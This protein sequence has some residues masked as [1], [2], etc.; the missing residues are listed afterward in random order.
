[1]R[2]ERARGN[3]KALLDG[4]LGSATTW[5]L[6]RH[7]ARCAGCQEEFEMIGRL[8]ALLL[9]AD[10][11][12]SVPAGSLGVWRDRRN[13]LRPLYPLVWAGMLALA[14][15]VGFHSRDPGSSNIA[16]AAAIEAFA[17]GKDWATWHFVTKEPD[18]RLTET[19]LRR[20][21]AFR[22]EIRQG[23]QLVE[24]RVQLGRESWIYQPDQ[25]RA[26]HAHKPIQNP[27]SYGDA[28]Y[29]LKDLQRRASKVGGLKV[30]ERPD[31][32]P[33]GRAVK[34]IDI[35]ADYAKH[36][37]PREGTHPKLAH[38]K[39]VVDA[40]TG[41]QVKSE[42]WNSVTTTIAHNQPMPDRLFVWK[43]PA[44][45]QVI[46][47]GDWQ[48][49]RLARTLASVKNE[50][51]SLTIHAV[52]LAANGDL[53]VTASW[54]FRDESMNTW[55][56]LPLLGDATDDRG[57]VYLIFSGIGGGGMG[58]TSQIVAYTPRESRSPADPLPTTIA[59]HH[60]GSPALVL[61]V[62]PPAAWTRPPIDPEGV[63]HPERDAPTWEKL[64]Q[65]VRSKAKTGEGRR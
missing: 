9:S 41:L 44:G 37:G 31:R 35:E 34:V 7:L 38:F 10:L 59:L 52:D 11:V 16:L 20:P 27:G 62:P 54:K 64:R 26:F 33:D 1:M 2:C 45:V 13:R 65:K 50:H 8:N 42:M 6:R 57:R 47:I 63:A 58:P 28:V 17:G 51:H 21:D 29:F 49:E 32:W 25:K 55:G 15:M 19:W 40:E 12:P 18:G 48:G 5:R 23:G 60:Y 4:E 53:W 14:L 24:L 3:L 61:P 46:E 22:A 30:T 43:P 56:T 39:V 36:F